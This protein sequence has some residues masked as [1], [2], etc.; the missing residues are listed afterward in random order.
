MAEFR[1]GAEAIAQASQRK[2]GGRFAPVFKFDAGETKYVQFL[3]SMDEIPTV[4]MHQFIVVGY[5]EDGNPKYE[6]FIS[7]R[8]PALDGPDGYDELIERFGVSPTNRSIALALEVEPEVTRSGGKK[9]IEGFVPATRQFERDGETV[10]VPAFGLIIESPNTFFTHLAANA[11][12]MA[13]EETI[14]AV[15][16]TGK[17]TDT[18][19]TFIPTGH[20][21]LDVEEELAEFAE[22]F[23]FEAWLDELADEDRMRE[24]IGPLPDDF[25]VSRFAK[26]GNDGGGRRSSR[27]TRAAASA[28]DGDEGG[29]EEAAEKPATGSRSSRFAAIR[30]ASKK[31]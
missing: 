14:F 18:T 8:D 17:S 20:D 24:L 29:E 6:R 11:D 16:R 5:R 2:S 12:L 3:M 4:L 26:K 31:K 7:R 13:I 22:W 28:D 9:T 1:R 19:Y 15:K 30:E 27:S 21:A 10:T 23:D 25:V